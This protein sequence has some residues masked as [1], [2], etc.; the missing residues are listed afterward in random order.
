MT[1]LSVGFGL[2]Y[3]S[4]TGS[5][6]LLSQKSKQG[7]VLGVHQS[8][9][10]VCRI[11][12]PVIGGFLYRDYHSTTPFLF[13]S[14]I[15]MVGLT[16]SF[17]FKKNIPHLGKMKNK[18][19]NTNDTKRKLLFA[20][21]NS[22]HLEEYMQIQWFQLMNLIQN[23]VPFSLFYLGDHSN[24]TDDSNHSLET[25]MVLQ[26]ATKIKNSALL[27]LRLPVDQPIILICKDGLS[28]QKIAQDLSKK[29]KNVFYLKGGILSKKETV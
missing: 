8:V 7:S 12:G 28:S 2:S 27:K 10:S 1:L 3:T 24:L 22:D 26:K 6:S 17:C 18:K 4:L 9:S 14:A 25:K 16:L 5:I 21:D 20:E 15:S 11:I 23:Q 13:A 29:Y 19:S